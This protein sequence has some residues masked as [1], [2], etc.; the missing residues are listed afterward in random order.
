MANN[1]PEGH[2]YLWRNLLPPE[3]A[4]RSLQ[5]NVVDQK[6]MYTRA[7]SEVR[8]YAPGTRQ[9][10]GTRLVD[11]GS[12]YCSQNVM[13]VHFGLPAS[14]PVDVEVTALTGT[15]RKITRLENVDSTRL[16][17]GTLTVKVG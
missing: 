16:S 10:L 7:G 4:R 15:G 5:V 6:G 1:N 13:P 14:G 3:R 11:T 17:R 9:V 2:H 8:I 12:G